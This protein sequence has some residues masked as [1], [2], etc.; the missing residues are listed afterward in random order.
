MQASFVTDIDGARERYAK[1]LQLNLTQESGSELLAKLRST[2]EP[3]CE[4]ITPIHIEYQ[5]RGATA[6]LKL[7]DDWHIRPAEQL[8]QRLRQL[9]GDENVLLDYGKRSSN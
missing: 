4:G 5:N 9:L 7:G 2:I 8:M 3:Y 1:K 6:Q